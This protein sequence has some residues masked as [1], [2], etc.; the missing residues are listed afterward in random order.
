[1]NIER[2]TVQAPQ[3]P[4]CNLGDGFRVQGLGFRSLSKRLLELLDV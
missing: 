3:L 4:L 2:E 1:M